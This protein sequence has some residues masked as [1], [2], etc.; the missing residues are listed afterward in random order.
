M[1]AAEIEDAQKSEVKKTQE[2]KDAE[3]SAA[4]ASAAIGNIF[5]T[6]EITP[7]PTD[8]FYPADR[9]WQTTIALGMGANALLGYGSDDLLSRLFPSFILTFRNYLSAELIQSIFRWAVV[10]HVVEGVVAL[11]ICLKRGWYSPVNI[12]KWT[13]STVLYGFASMSKLLGHAKKVKR[14]AKK[15]E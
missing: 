12:M 13:G 11:G 15:M 7:V 1:R 8:V 5:A 14:A 10:T 2:D 3:A 4:I 6:D 9:F